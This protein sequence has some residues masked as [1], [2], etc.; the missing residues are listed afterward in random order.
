MD[1]RWT[2]S[3]T[4][5]GSLRRCPA[6]AADKRGGEIV[7]DRT[8]PP[9]LVGLLNSFQDSHDPGPSPAEGLRMVRAFSNIRDVAV[10]VAIIELIE[11]IADGTP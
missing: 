9:E 3:G 7:V 4:M 6:L 10:R 2:P 11:R 8:L 1:Y 5:S